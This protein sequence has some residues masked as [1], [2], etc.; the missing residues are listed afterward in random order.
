MKSKL[1][2]TLLCTLMIASALA[3]CLGGD[4]DP[5]EDAVLGCTYADATNYNADA[6]E[7][8]G[9]CEYAPGDEPVL[10]C[11]NAGATNYD[12]AATRDDG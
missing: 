9:S 7:D 3:G 8:D 5:G 2:A 10:G 1:T 6:T 11:T 4:D 12:S